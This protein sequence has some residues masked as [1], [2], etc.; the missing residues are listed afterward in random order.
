MIVQTG[1]KFSADTLFLNAIFSSFSSLLI[2]QPCK[3]KLHPSPDLNGLSRLEKTQLSRR[4]FFTYAGISAGAIVVGTS[5]QKD[6]RGG[7]PAAA[8]RPGR[9][10]NMPKNTVNLGSG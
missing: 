2:N 8:F 9:S 3:T 10:E 5:C 6:F 7:E 4:K 1:I